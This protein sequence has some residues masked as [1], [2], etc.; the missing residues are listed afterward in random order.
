MVGAVGRVE[1]SIED[2]KGLLQKRLP[3]VRIP[4]NARHFIFNLW[5]GRMGGRMEEGRSGPFEARCWMGVRLSACRLF[6]FSLKHF[7]W[8]TSLGMVLLG[9]ED[10]VRISIWQRRA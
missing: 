7:S 5:A 4:G 10:C 6:P 2:V 8:S 9:L 1:T 3:A